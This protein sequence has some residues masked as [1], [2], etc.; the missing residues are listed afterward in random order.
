[1]SLLLDCR[2]GLVSDYNDSNSNIMDHD[3]GSEIISSDVREKIAMLVDI[4]A[5]AI[6]NLY[7]PHVELVYFI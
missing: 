7:K 3:D 4:G 6:F 1:M 5:Q 2:L